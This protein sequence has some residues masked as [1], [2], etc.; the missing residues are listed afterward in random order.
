MTYSLL[1]TLEFLDAIGA[2]EP[3]SETPTNKRTL[4]PVSATTL[5]QKQ[6]EPPKRAL[7][8]MHLKPMNAN[9]ADATT[10]ASNAQTLEELRQALESFD[11]CALKMTAT[12][13]VF[14]DGN[15]QA[16]VMLVGEAPGADED[17]LGRPFVGLS[18]Q[19]L[20]KAFQTIGYDRTRLYISN[21][22]PWRPPGNRPPTT[23]ELALCLPF[24]ERHI[25]LV[26]PKI[27]IFVGG[28]AAK[29]LLR[30][31]DGIT[32]LRGRWT[33]YMPLGSTLSIPATAIFHPAYLLRSPG[34]KKAVWQD[35]LK[36][37]KYLEE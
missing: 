17:R 37:K 12:N 19:L 35:L 16:E 27:L 34:Q 14:A 28:T 8:P 18:G 31:N 22:L 29:A 21:M 23:E 9:I 13:T 24:I 15:P 20:D 6:S 2:G 25:A 5:F 4:V 33:Q 7:A 26:A 3:L 10:L 11:A 32:K 36:I 30:T 1:Q